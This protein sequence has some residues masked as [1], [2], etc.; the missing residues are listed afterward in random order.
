[1]FFGRCYIMSDVVDVTEVSMQEGS[2]NK[3]SSA[4]EFRAMLEAFGKAMSEA[5]NDPQLKDK[6]RDLGNSIASAAKT[7]G[8]RFQDEDVKRQFRQAGQAAQAF[9]KSVADHF[10][11]DK[12]ASEPK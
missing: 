3:R 5:F 6:A 4:E 12:N 7:A 8:G 11:A 2:N 10:R 9:G 1:M